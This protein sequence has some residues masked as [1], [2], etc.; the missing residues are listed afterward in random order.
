MEN[1]LT[2]YAKSIGYKCKVSLVI[3]NAIPSMRI[4]LEKFNEGKKKVYTYGEEITSVKAIKLYFGWKKSVVEK[5]EGTFSL[6]FFDLEPSDWKCAMTIAVHMADFDFFDGSHKLQFPSIDFMMEEIYNLPSESMVG[7]VEEYLTDI[8]CSEGRWVSEPEKKLAEKEVK[9]YIIK[10]SLEDEYLI[11]FNKD[12]YLSEVI[13]KYKILYRIVLE[14]AN[15]VYGQKVKPET[16]INCKLDMCELVWLG[17]WAAGDHEKPV[18]YSKIINEWLELAEEVRRNIVKC[19]Y[20]YTVTVI[21]ANFYRDWSNFFS[22]RPLLAELIWNSMDRNELLSITNVPAKKKGTAA[23]CNLQE[24]K[25]YVAKFGPKIV[26]IMDAREKELRRELED[27]KRE[28]EYDPYLKCMIVTNKVYKAEQKLNDYVNKNKVKI[29]AKDEKQIQNEI[30]FAIG[31]I[32]L[33]K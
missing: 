23:K 33:K 14:V 31:S 13:G 19:N 26:T 1:F 2:F 10:K 3:C 8:F 21:G 32:S 15:M 7:Y 11:Y 22:V 5:T 27:A 28:Q 24:M 29:V 16:L 6:D 12:W 9:D 20:D 25:E 17:D 18:R 30:K 4:S